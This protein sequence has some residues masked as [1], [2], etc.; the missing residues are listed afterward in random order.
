MPSSYCP[1]SL[2]WRSGLISDNCFLDLS[3]QKAQGNKDRLFKYAQLSLRWGFVLREPL[4]LNISRLYLCLYLPRPVASGAKRIYTKW[5][6]EK[7]HVYFLESNWNSSR[8]LSFHALL[9][10]SLWRRSEYAVLVCSPVPSRA[11]SRTISISTLAGSMPVSI[12]KRNL[13]IANEYLRGK[14]ESHVLTAN[15]KVLREV[16][17]K[18]TKMGSIATGREP[19]CSKAASSNECAQKRY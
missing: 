6:W 2:S 10:L 16:K 4:A 1:T 13:A 14:E 3:F 8:L 17:G 12:S 19:R 7:S 9:W 18:K 11:G 5:R 15:H